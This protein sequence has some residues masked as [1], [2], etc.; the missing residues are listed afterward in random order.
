MN[1]HLK[2]VF[3]IILPR[4]YK[5]GINYWITGGIAIAGINGSFYRN[6]QDVDLVLDINDYD[7]IKKLVYDLQA[8]YPEWKLHEKF[9]S[10]GRPKINLYEKDKEIFSVIPIYF[11]KKDVT[12]KYPDG[13]FTFKRELM[14]PIERTI[15]QYK[16]P[17]GSDK[18][19][20]DLLIIYLDI[21]KAGQKYKKLQSYKEDAK[22]ILTPEEFNKYY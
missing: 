6:N 5:S 1:E 22:L 10:N 14:F 16:F 17:T 9:L 11:D 2:S 8:E 7:K 20:K 3:E 18:I 4:I 13:D 15:D 19:I 12:F 21:L